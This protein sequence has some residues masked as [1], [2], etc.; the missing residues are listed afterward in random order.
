MH[1]GGQRVTF[2]MFFKTVRRPSIIMSDGPADDMHLGE[3]RFQG[4]IGF[5][6]GG[7]PEIGHIRLEQSME[8]DNERYKE[9]E[10]KR[11]GHAQLA[12]G[13]WEVVWRDRVI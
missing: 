10:M 2:L 12:R 1:G 11:M 9:T 7:I 13:H 3:L 5:R 4:S 8:R 6:S